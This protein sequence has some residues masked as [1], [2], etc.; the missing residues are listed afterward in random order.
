MYA[1]RRTSKPSNSC[2]SF[3]ALLFVWTKRLLHSSNVLS[4]AEVC[5]DT[6]L[7]PVSNQRN[8]AQAGFKSAC[9]AAGD[10]ST[11]SSDEYFLPTLPRMVEMGGWG[12]FH[13]NTIL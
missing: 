6:K 10:I 2:F 4:F 9:A 5:L 1:Y 12:G 3:P 13:R 11:A 7:C 8:G